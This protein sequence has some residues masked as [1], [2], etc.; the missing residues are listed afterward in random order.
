MSRHD[1]VGQVDGHPFAPVHRGERHASFWM[2]PCIFQLL[3][4]S[5]SLPV[6]HVH[7]ADALG[8][9]LLDLNKQ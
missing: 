6:G 9:H 7:V 3:L 2:G 1:L 8:E 4:G 5:G